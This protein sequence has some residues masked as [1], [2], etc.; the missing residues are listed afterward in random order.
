M[1]TSSET[2]RRAVPWGKI[3]LKNRCNQGTSG[4]MAAAWG[5]VAPFPTRAKH[6]SIPNRKIAER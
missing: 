4:D 2:K 6:Y 5:I 1:D 3:A